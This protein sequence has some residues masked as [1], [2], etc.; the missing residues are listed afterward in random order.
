MDFL[1][2]ESLWQ[3]LNKPLQKKEALHIARQ[4]AA[5]LE[6]AHEEGVIHRDLTSGN[7]ML[8]PRSDG[9]TRA[10]ILDFG[11]AC[12]HEDGLPPVAL[13][14]TLPYIAPERWNDRGAAA[15]PSSDIYSF[16]V[17]LYEMLTGRHPFEPETPIEDR[18]K[19]PPA[20]STIRRGIEHRWDR[21]ILRCLD[22]APQKRFRR[23]TEAINALRPPRW[24]IAVAAVFLIG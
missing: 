6:A 16:G 10:V 18:K 22:P 12:T 21:V 2:G 17:I 7:V 1:E 24:P 4:I 11:I 13:V 20:P 3:R 9:T 19:L 8:V 5:G 23:A 15:H 14:G